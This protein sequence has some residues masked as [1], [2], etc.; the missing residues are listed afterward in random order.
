MMSADRGLLA[1]LRPLVLLATLDTARRGSP[2]PAWPPA[3]GNS[4]Q[5]TAGATGSR[6]SKG[7]AGDGTQAGKREVPV[8]VIPFEEFKERCRKRFERI[9]VTNL[10]RPYEGTM[11]TLKVSLDRTG[12]GEYTIR[13]GEA[14]ISSND[15]RTEVRLRGRM[16]FSMSKANDGIVGTV[17]S[18]GL[19]LLVGGA[20]VANW[21]LWKGF[22][23][24]CPLELAREKDGFRGYL[25][26]VVPLIVGGV[27]VAGAFALPCEMSEDRSR[28][29]IGGDGVLDPE[30]L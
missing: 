30:Q 26:L 10:V 25:S 2:P 12:D 22:E 4:A 27:D 20:R 5:R 9:E 19:D 18:V 15:R 28:M 14:S 8:G 7:V 16:T 23:G 6:D 1:V 29:L 13:D 21:R 3:N 17:D 11:V 24:E